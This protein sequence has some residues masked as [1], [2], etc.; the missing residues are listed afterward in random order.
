MSMELE[1]T[2]FGPVQ[3][4]LFY[5]S[6]N[7]LSMQRYSKNGDFPFLSVSAIKLESLITKITKQDMK[8]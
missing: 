5:H 1:K 7:K 2:L 6:T 8:L 4:K 3:L